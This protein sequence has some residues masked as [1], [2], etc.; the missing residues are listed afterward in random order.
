M[1]FWAAYYAHNLFQSA[2]PMF[3]SALKP[4]CHKS[5]HTVVM[6]KHSMDA[7][8]R[9]VQHINPGL[10]PVITFDQLL[11]AIT[12]VIKWKWSKKYWEDKVAILFGG[13]HIEVAAPKTARAW[14][15]GSGWVEALVQA[16]IASALKTLQ[17]QH[18]MT[19]QE[20]L[21]MI[22]YYH[23]KTYVK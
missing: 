16:D 18:L 5:A 14:L 9:A 19:M 21:I 3:V 15:G 1:M 17:H 10:S 12:K 6:I 7:I 2:R 8:K 4:L 23:S 20:Q 22:N 11:F 13:L